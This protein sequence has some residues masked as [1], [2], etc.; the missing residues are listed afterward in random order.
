MLAAEMR[1]D[2]DSVKEDV[3]YKGLKFK[4]TQD[5]VLRQSL[6]CTEGF[7]LIEYA[8]WGD[9]YWGVD[10]E[11]NGQ[12]RLGVLLMRLRDELKGAS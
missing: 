3:M 9:T 10:K 4:F 5:E 1:A 8:P 7:E 11:Y 2:W 6:L 12:N